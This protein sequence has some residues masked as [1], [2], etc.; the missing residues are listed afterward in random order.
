[1]TTSPTSVVRFALP[2]LT[3]LGAAATAMLLGPGAALLVVAT[4]ALV[5]VILLLWQSVQSLTGESAITLEEALG[6]GARSAEEEQKRAVL[7]G[8]KDL[9]YERSVG[10]ISEEDYREISERYR[11]EA[12]RLLR[13]IDESVADARDVEELVRRRL[14]RENLSARTEARSEDAEAHGSEGTPTD[15]QPTDDDET[16]D[17]TPA[18]GDA[19]VPPVVHCTACDAEND[20]DAVFCKKCGSRLAEAAP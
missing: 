13:I 6:L 11:G 17:P 2:L 18:S 16:S 14:E 5:G 12:R 19:S 1:M 10:K 20:D 15:A 7:R 4:G 8:L 9:E 3:V